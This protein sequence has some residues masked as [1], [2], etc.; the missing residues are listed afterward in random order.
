[1][2]RI[3][4]RTGF[5]NTFNIEN[6]ERFRTFLKRHG[7]L[8]DTWP[9]QPELSRHAV[10]VALLS[11]ALFF[12]FDIMHTLNDD[13]SIVWWSVHVCLFG[14]FYFFLQPWI[15]FFSQPL[16]GKPS[17][18]NFYKWY[19]SWLL[20]AAVYHL[21]SSQSVAMSMR[22]N[23]SLF[24]TTF[25]SSIM[26]LLAFHY[27][28]NC[29]QYIISCEARKWPDIW[30]ILQFSAA[31]SIACCV[32]LSHCRERPLEQGYLK[33]KVCSSWLAPVESASEY[34]YQLFCMLDN[35]GRIHYFYCKLPSSE[36]PES[37]S[38]KISLVYSSW[39]TFIGLY[40]A[41]YVAERSLGP[42]EKYK[43][44]KQTKP[45]F[46]D[47]V[48]WY[49]GTSA[50]LYKTVFD[51]M[52]SVTVF[53]GRFDMRILQ[54]AMNQNQVE[55]KNKNEAQAGI[56]QGDYLYDH[57]S[58]G[59][60][61]WFDFMADTGD[62]G[63]STYAVARLL[64]Q[65]QIKIDSAQK[66]K[67]KI[68]YDTLKRGDLLLIGGDL[69]YPNPSEFTYE[70]RLFR[71][72]K[73]AFQPPSCNDQERMVVNKPTVPPGVS[74]ERR[75]D[76]K[77]T[78][79]GKQP[80]SYNGPQC[81]V[82][83]G[84]H[85]WFDG[86][87]TFTRYICHRSWLGGWFMPQKKSYF[88]L[89]LPMG[90]WIFG[91]DLALHGDIDVYQFEFFSKLARKTVRRTDSVIIMTH[92]PDWLLDWYENDDS[93]K[94]ASDKQSKGNNVS[95]LIY[96][97]LKERCRL[98]IAGD[99]HHYMRHSTVSSNE[100]NSSQPNKKNESVY[101]QH[102][103]VN[104]CGGAFT[105]PT[106]VFRDFNE[107][108]GVSYKCKN[109]YPSY[110]MSRRLALRN[111]WNFRK[112][113]WQ[114]DF[115]GGIIYF[116]LVFSMFPQC[117][118]DHIFEE[119][120]T[121][122]FSRS[123]FGTV[124]NA[125]MYL[126]EHSYVSLGGAT[127]LLIVA[128]AFVPSKVSCKTRILIGVLHA[129]IHLAAALILMLV[130]ELGIEF[131]VRQKLV[132]TSGYHSLYR[133]HQS[134]FHRHLPVPVVIQDSIKRW[135]FGL[136]PACIKYIM[137]T[138]DVP[139]LM[140][141]TRSNVCK[142]GME[143]I[144]RW[145]AI[146]YYASIFL[147][148]WVLSTPA[149]SFVFGSYLYICINWFNLH[150]DEAFSSLRIADYKAFTRFHIKHNG[151]LEIFTLAVDKVPEE[152]ELDPKWKGQ[153]S[154][155]LSHLRE[156][157]SQWKAADSD[158]EPLKTVRIIDKFNIPRKHSSESPDDTSGSETE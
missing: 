140:A 108:H 26:F 148:F 41:N 101:P 100:S 150:Y 142:N 103:L 88:A 52:L 134:M 29:L 113:N 73:Y 121:S 31:V 1:M 24:L 42:V 47:M 30:A 12:F 131:L 21:P 102:L 86:L 155:E 4:V 69:A 125:F 75:Q 158:Q 83:P 63:N 20:V 7:F 78:K 2:M 10:M 97:I 61:L 49:S 50:D 51:L 6:M 13:N 90:W 5:L 107:S 77:R 122:G 60:E 96:N 114:F 3:K 91:L 36:S 124:W 23:L 38:D 27:I 93:R 45:D 28:Y 89:Q 54:A 99:I 92:Q 80:T 64:A 110:K 123:F 71:P 34:Y 62:G 39:A 126:L 98:R 117:K 18:S 59:K 68:D 112:E 106:H 67:Y 157:P 57:F 87:H 44:N 143:S 35:Y 66:E 58:K 127:L 84:N 19:V 119:D 151:D 136:Y 120:S 65:P 33:D 149:V 72:F 16:I 156:N 82:I 56:Q 129:S 46:F 55:P 37:S 133:W 14:F 135:T 128:V 17:Y 111:I 138:F 118:L 22:M 109:A 95:D 132:E 32:F 74:R 152:W 8:K 115:I 137:S 15:R 81:F 104:G 116:I 146:L 11:C 76:R 79:R 154:E 43:K 85:D 94:D 130:F 70:R 53:L 145:G 139:E 153:S 25:A 141:V 147:Y 105:H 40:I 48:P 9:S 144:S